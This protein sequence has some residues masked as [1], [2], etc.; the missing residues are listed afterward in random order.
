MDGD[1]FSD[2]THMNESKIQNTFNHIETD[3]KAMVISTIGSSRVAGAD[4]SAY[5]VNEMKD[6]L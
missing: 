6:P 4:Y 5:Y 2:S 1:G 3:W